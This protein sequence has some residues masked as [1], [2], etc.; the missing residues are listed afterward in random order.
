MVSVYTPAELFP[1]AGADE[2][3]EAPGS[4]V[5]EA[6]RDPEAVLPGGTTGVK[7]QTP[8]F[9]VFTVEMG[10][11]G[12]GPLGVVVHTVRDGQGA[13]LLWLGRIWVVLERGEGDINRW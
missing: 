13:L 7:G 8:H 5:D 1:A 3:A 12:Q 2:C 10:D 9:R 11:P 6:W 4:H